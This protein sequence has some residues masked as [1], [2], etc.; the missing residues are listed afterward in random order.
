MIQEWPS[1][2]KILCLYR[3]H[4]K[5]GSSILE[6]GSFIPILPILLSL[7]GYKVT[8]IDKESLYYDELSIFS[9]VLKKFDIASFNGDILQ[10][11]LNDLDTKFDAVNLTFVLE[12]LNDLLK[13]YY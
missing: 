7:D 10:G 12:H 3:K 1:Y 9:K 13:N 6:V 8:I 4:I 11:G 2:I 5:R